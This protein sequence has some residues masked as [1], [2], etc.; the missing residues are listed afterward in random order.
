MSVRYLSE[1]LFLASRFVKSYACIAC[2][3]LHAK[4]CIALR[5]SGHTGRGSE[6]ILHLHE[7]RCIKRAGVAGIALRAEIVVPEYLMK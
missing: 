1:A 5:R 7:K 4:P 2:M 3:D 6:C